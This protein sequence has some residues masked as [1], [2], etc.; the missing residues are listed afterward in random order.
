[1]GR[2]PPEERAVHVILREAAAAKLAALGKVV[3]TTLSSHHDEEAT[4]DPSIPIPE[5]GCTDGVKTSFPEEPESYSVRNSTSGFVNPVHDPRKFAT[6]DIGVMQECR[7]SDMSP[8]ARR[9]EHPPTEYVQLSLP[10]PPPPPRPLPSQGKKC[11]GLAS[12]SSYTQPRCATGVKSCDL[13][14][15]ALST[16]VQ[17]SLP[18]RRLFTTTPDVSNGP[19]ERIPADTDSPPPPPEA[20][21]V[22]K[23][24]PDHCQDS[25]ETHGAEVVNASVVR[26][27]AVHTTPISSPPSAAAH[28]RQSHHLEP[29]RARLAKSSEPTT[30]PENVPGSSSAAAA[31]CS[32]GAGSDLCVEAHARGESNGIAVEGVSTPVPVATHCGA[33]PVDQLMP[34]PPPPPRKFSAT[35]VVLPPKLVAPISV[36]TMALPGGSP[37]TD[38]EKLPLV[39]NSG[40]VAVRDAKTTDG[41]RSIS[42]DFLTRTPDAGRSVSS[43]SA[44]A[45]A[46]AQRTTTGEE[47]K[48]ASPSSATAHHR[49]GIDMRAYVGRNTDNGDAVVS[50]AA[51]AIR[52]MLS[53]DRPKEDT[54]DGVTAEKSTREVVR[55]HSMDGEELRFGTVLEGEYE[56]EKVQLFYVVHVI[57]VN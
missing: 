25:A 23:P 47:D 8:Q 28:A 21:T 41:T 45:P 48:A 54:K 29:P 37:G 32:A 27:S 12:A 36:T 7:Q 34:P 26:A 33:A 1:M 4:D 55:L 6:V 11:T 35:N 5:D 9:M 30:C 38:D 40:D 31:A 17:D 22:H 24:T 46:A 43:Q 3:H 15:G 52:E 56:L 42:S 2:N 10:L 19:T 13:S 44:D 51:E 50:P 39:F 49:D 14:E 16:S 57:V 18:P 53:G 20:K